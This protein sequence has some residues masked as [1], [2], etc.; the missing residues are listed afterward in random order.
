MS[1]FVTSASSNLIPLIN[2]ATAI[3]HPIHHIRQTLLT[4]FQIIFFASP[5]KVLSL[6][7]AIS[8]FHPLCPLLAACGIW[9]SAAQG[10]VDVPDEL[11]LEHL[12]IAH[13]VTLDRRSCRRVDS[14]GSHCLRCINR[15]CTAS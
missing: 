10:V 3:H 9:H 7:H 15:D 6:V 4:L 11:V 5:A 12:L 1:C 13:F 2:I 14:V 8:I